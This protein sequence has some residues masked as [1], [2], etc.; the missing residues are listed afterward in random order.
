[1]SRNGMDLVSPAPP[2]VLVTLTKAVRKVIK[3]QPAISNQGCRG[4]CGGQTPLL[5]TPEAVYIR[6]LSATRKANCPAISSSRCRGDSGG[7]AHFVFTSG[8]VSNNHRWFSPGG[9]YSA[10]SEAIDHTTITVQLVR[11]MSIHNKTHPTKQRELFRSRDHRPIPHTT[12]YVY[13]M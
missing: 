8:Y 1:M 12:I 5:F 4:D 7:K 11:L 13:D 10:T 6:P 2:Y 3:T 9:S